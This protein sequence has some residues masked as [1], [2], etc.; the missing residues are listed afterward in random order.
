M[1]FIFICSLLLLPFIAG[2]SD[3]SKDQGSVTAEILAQS[4]R[5]WNGAKLPSYPTEDPEITVLKVT[6][7]AGAKLDWHKHPS[8]NVGYL[9]S[10]ELTVFAED[11]QKKKLQ[12]G[13]AL[14]ELV[15]TW[16][17]GQ[18]TGHAPA[19]IV[20]VYVGVEGRPLS[21]MKNDDT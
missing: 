8:I 4:D 21:I 20:V 18:N 16:H 3:Y 5:T 17:R 15:E 11:G 13:D 9:V 12:A 10:G 14:I 19:E 7:P 1:K 2:A 6:I